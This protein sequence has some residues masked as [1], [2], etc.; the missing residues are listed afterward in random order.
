M[1]F[2]QW[3][4]G[5]YSIFVGA[6]EAPRGVG[7]I[8]AVVVTRATEGPARGR[9]AYRDDNLACGHRWRSAEEAM[10]YAMQRARDLVRRRSPMLSC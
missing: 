1:Q 6:L 2:T 5:D 9:E 8:A 10:A 4:E 3:R 7:Y